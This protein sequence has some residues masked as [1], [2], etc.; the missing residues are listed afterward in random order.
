MAAVMDVREGA[1]GREGR[2]T[3]DGGTH[4]VKSV[5]S[6]PVPE[7][8]L[9]TVSALSAQTARGPSPSQLSIPVA[10]A[11]ERE[12][13]GRGTRAQKAYRS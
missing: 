13:E 3:R 9:L 4:R 12:R 8:A 10:Q 2:G 11:S 1:E 7:Y 6:A 5:L